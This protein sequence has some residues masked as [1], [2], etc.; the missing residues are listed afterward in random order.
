[1]INP[2]VL[3]IGKSGVGKSTLLNY[4]FGSEIQ[5]TG[6]GAP[7]SPKEFKKCRYKYDE[8]LIIN[9]YDT[10]G[11]EAGKKEEWTELIE[12]EKEMMKVIQLAKKEELER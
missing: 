9:I 12:K 3:V 11:L 8:D 5:K 4:I 1:M 6:T 7:Q 10:W 2:N